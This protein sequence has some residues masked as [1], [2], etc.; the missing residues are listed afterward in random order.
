MRLAVL[1][2]LAQIQKAE[3]HRQAQRGEQ[4]RAASQTRRRRTPWRR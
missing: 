2:Y 3:R 1:C 4:A